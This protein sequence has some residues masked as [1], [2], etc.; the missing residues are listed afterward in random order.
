MHTH[1]LLSPMV[2]YDAL[3][4]V[5]LYERSLHIV[6]FPPC[7]CLYCVLLFLNQEGP[8]ILLLPLISV[9][10]FPLTDNLASASAITVATK[11][12]ICKGLEKKEG[13]VDGPLCF[14]WWSAAFLPP[15]IILL[16]FS[17]FLYS[18][19]YH[20]VGGEV[21]RNRVWSPQMF[22]SSLH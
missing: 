6:F 9:G 22:H 4:V 14:R 17:P 5:Y 1:L 8:S 20:G 13:F 7:F 2:L 19:I 12:R 11:R 10:V 18:T 16:L 21:E 3:T 15:L